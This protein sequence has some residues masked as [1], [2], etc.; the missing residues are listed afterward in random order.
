[1]KKV[2]W[3]VDTESFWTPLQ[4]VVRCAQAW[5]CRSLGLQ[6][7]CLSLSAFIPQTKRMIVW[8][9][10]KLNTS[11]IVTWRN[12]ISLN[13]RCK[14]GK[15][16][17]QLGCELYE[18]HAAINEAQA[19]LFLL[20]YIIISQTRLSIETGEGVHRNTLF[21]I[22]FAGWFKMLQ[23][24]SFFFFRGQ[25]QKRKGNVSSRDDVTK[26][27]KLKRLQDFTVTRN[28]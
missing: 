14:K 18:Q 2:T 8:H 13:V 25:M 7:H 4:C 20:L 24:N 6:I 28:N 10:L 16:K 9:L 1:M 11:V 23:L 15:R 26:W 21:L 5:F 12:M 17:S 3:Y 19:G 27:T 22:W